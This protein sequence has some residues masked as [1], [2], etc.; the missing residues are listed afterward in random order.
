MGCSWLPLKA[1]P[2]TNSGTGWGLSFIKAP[3]S[4]AV[5]DRV[6]TSPP[7]G[8]EVLRNTIMPAG[9]STGSGIAVG[10]EAQTSRT[11]VDALWCLHRVD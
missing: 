9:W 8:P 7:L 4:A 10:L 5:R 3:R 6:E 2:L 1:C 11:E